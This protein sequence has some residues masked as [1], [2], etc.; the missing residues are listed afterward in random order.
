MM[1]KTKQKPAEIKEAIAEL[2]VVI[3]DGKTNE[4][5]ATMIKMLLSLKHKIS[6]KEYGELV[7]KVEKKKIR[8]FG[9][10]QMLLVEK[11]RGEFANL[12]KK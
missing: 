2:I 7:D 9:K 11:I 1:K 5:F 6:P 12:R 8:I 4:D 3:N 10:A